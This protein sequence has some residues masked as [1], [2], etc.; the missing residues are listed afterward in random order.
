MEFVLEFENLTKQYRSFASRRRIVAL[1]SFS[2]RVEPGEIFGFLG[3]NGAGKSTAIHLAMGFM[4]PSSG[5]GRMLGARFGDSHAR[6]KVGFLAENVALYHRKAERLIRFYGALNGM[7]GRG[8]AQ[9]SREVLQLVGLQDHSTRNVGKFSRGMLQRAGLAQALVNDPELLILDEP[10]SALDPLARVMVRELLLTARN[11][12]K[13]IFLSSHLLSEVELVC[14]RVAVLHRGRLV[15]VGRT[16]DLLVSDEHSEIVARGI[17]AAAFDNAS[18][19]D[20]V[21]R[22]SVPSKRQREMLERIWS[23]GGEVISVNPARRSLE[24]IFLEVTSDAAT[25]EKTQ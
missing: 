3:P 9:R 8:L 21:V 10:T 25:S 22:L 16:A 15:H 24:D 12:G 17:S 1:D 4:R 23:C 19:H 13:T 5:T 6:K 20:G 7:G 18:A 14:D 2:L 11:Q